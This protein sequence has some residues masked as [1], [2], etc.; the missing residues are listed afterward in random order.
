MPKYRCAV[1]IPTKN[2][3][4]RFVRVL[5]M[6]RRQKT[7]WPFEIIVI[8]S[9]SKDGTLEYVNNR[10][11][12]HLIQIKPSEFGHGRT[13]NQAIAA[14]DAEFVALITHDAEPLDKHWLANL[15][16]AA[17][18]DD[19]IA[20]VFGRHV[21]YNDAS[22]FTKRDLDRHFAGFLNNP[23]VVHRDINP[24]KYANDQGW[25]RFLHFFSDNNSLVR[26]SVWEQMPYPDVE[27]AED[28]I[29]ARDIIEAGYAKAYA[30][31]AVVIHSHDY[32]CIQQM[33]RAFDE[34]RNFEKYFGYRL[35][36]SLRQAIASAFGLCVRASVEKID[37][38]KYGSVSGIARAKRF[39][40]Q[41]ALLTGHYLGSKHR[42]FP[43]W[44]QNILSLDKR[45]FDQ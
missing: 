2:A 34:S 13:R 15:V 29:W 17:E 25:C 7:P 21:A 1:I 26:K 27:F 28:Q 30:P 41:T 40:Q 43:A 5:E 35:T 14:A 18:Q 31:D 16:S 20:G 42:V 39:G 38:E 44:F 32:S 33:R 10:P 23:L 36:G 12:V 11:D 4:P 19:R 3:M 9:G 24:E 45:L 37:H 22:P 8:D 6:V